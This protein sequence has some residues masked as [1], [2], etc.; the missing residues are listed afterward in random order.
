MGRGWET[1][2]FRLFVVACVKAMLNKKPIRTSRREWVADEKEEEEE[3]EEEE[4]GE[5]GERPF[6]LILLL[7]LEEE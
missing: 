2:V 1:K 6:F 3:E 5:E 7:L 4:G